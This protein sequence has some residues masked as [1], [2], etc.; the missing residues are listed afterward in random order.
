MSGDNK[1]WVEDGQE[2]DAMLFKVD[3]KRDEMRFYHLQLI[4]ESNKDL[5]VL[6]TRWGEIGETGQFQRTPAA[7]REEGFKEFCKVFKEKTGNVF[8]SLKTAD[9]AAENQ[10]PQFEK[11]PNKYH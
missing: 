11:K 10:I 4:F 7:S 5:H 9:E 6:L 1:V 3:L 2:C 8:Q